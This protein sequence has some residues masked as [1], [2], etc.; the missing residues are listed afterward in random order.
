MLQ[1]ET[2]KD[3]NV[4]P[5]Q[6]FFYDPITKGYDNSFW[7]TITGTPTISSGVLILNDASISSFI[8]TTYG[9]LE[10]A[11]VFPSDLADSSNKILG[12]FNP[13]GESQIVF[14]FE[15]GDLIARVVDDNGVEEEITIDP[16]LFP[17]DA[18]D[19]KL[20]IS[21]SPRS[22]AFFINDVSCA[23]FEVEMEQPL[24]MYASNDVAE[25][26]GLEYISLKDAGR[27]N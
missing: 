22:V 23:A 24:A 7:G 25:A 17:M 1:S 15:S 11:G 4:T 26:F 9:V 8:Q 16:V 3:T 19:H 21:W 2:Y 6:G 5:P 14:S 27:I 12:F 18:G 10:F 20:K 13:A